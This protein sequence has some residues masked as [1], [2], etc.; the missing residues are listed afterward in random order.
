MAKGR[1]ADKAILIAIGNAIQGLG[2]A[3]IGLF[4]V[5][6]FADKETYGSYRQVWLVIQTM[7]PLFLVGLPASV[8]FFIPGLTPGQRRTFL[9]RAVAFLTGS[10]LLF[11]ILMYAFAPQIAA[12]LGGNLRI[13]PILRVFCLYP[14]FT[15]PS[16]LLFPFLVSTEEHRR[17]IVINI[18]FFLAQSTLIVAL[19]AWGLALA[20]LFR[21]LVALAALRFL[22]SLYEMHRQ[23]RDLGAESLNVTLRRNLGYSIPVGLSNVATILGQ[24]LDRVVV[25]ALLGTTLFAV[26]DVGAVEFPGIV[27]LAMA[28]NSVMQPH[29]AGLHHARRT[30]EIHRFWLE[31]YRMQALVFIPMAVYLACFAREFIELLYTPRY[32]DAAMVFQIYLML[33]LFRNANPVVILTSVGLT[34]VAFYGTVVFLIANLFLNLLLV[35]PLGLAGPPIA[36]VVAM[37]GLVSYYAIRAARHLRI[38]W[39]RM[40]PI[41][42]TAKVI[43]VSAAAGL[44]A[45]PV[46]GLGWNRIST[47][48]AGVAV[49]GLVYLLIGS[50]TRVIRREDLALARR[51]MTLRAVRGGG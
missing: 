14:L 48:G 10:G 50:L 8:Y 39:Q 44:A 12:V 6:L 20:P 47:L 17:G 30:D 16:M 35:G 13:V 23:T 24:R 51:W 32:G 40:F 28:A 33:T 49:F 41:W 34:R 45:L 36:T 1:L 42:M 38:R 3:A 22:Y 43:A 27:L 4:L 21:T 25:S 11:S 5:R 29:I 2:N 37:G 31:A 19:A 18:T 46:R 15:A 9:A 26:Y 7:L